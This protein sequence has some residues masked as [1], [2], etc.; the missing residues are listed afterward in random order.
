MVS[1]FENRL[2]NLFNHTICKPIAQPIVRIN[3]IFVRH[4]PFYSSVRTAKQTAQII[5]SPV[6]TVCPSVRN[7]YSSVRTADQ[8]VQIIIHPFERLGKP[9]ERFK[10]RSLTVRHPFV[11]AVRTVFRQCPSCLSR[12][13]I[14]QL[15]Y[16]RP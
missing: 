3:N 6:G 7:S 8:T 4:Y 5:Y 15:V 12:S 9:F 11:F 2:S 16:K 10:D 1:G 13:H 14:M